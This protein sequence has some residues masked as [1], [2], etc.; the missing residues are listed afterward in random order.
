MDPKSQNEWTVFAAAFRV[1]ISRL[2]D[3]A[4]VSPVRSRGFSS[5]LREYVAT[6]DRNISFWKIHLSLFP[7]VLIPFSGS[8]P[9][10]GTM[11][12]GAVYRR[13]G[14]GPGTAASAGGA[15]A[16]ERERERE[17]ETTD[18]DRPRLQ[19]GRT[20][21]PETAFPETVDGCPISDAD[22]NGVFRRDRFDEHSQSV[23]GRRNNYTGG[24]VASEPGLDWWQAEPGLG[25]VADGVADRVDRIKALGNGQVPACAAAAFLM[26]YERI[27]AL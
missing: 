12:N 22:L 26:L 13:P 23:T 7:E 2:L 9:R 16:R 14:L 19:T 21:R 20:L 25:R 10:W 1:R 8:L 27:N 18:A 15:S 11:R 4:R 3:S 24:K 6:F 17:R 5:S